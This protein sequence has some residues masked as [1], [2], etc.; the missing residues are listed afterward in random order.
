M[1]GNI[2]LTFAAA[3][4]VGTGAAQAQST[5]S[6]W[7]GVYTEAQAQHGEA[8]YRQNC[9]YCHGQNL[10][11]TFEIAPLMGR[12]MPYWSGTTL[13]VLMDYVNTAMPLGR[14][15]AVSR[16]D[17]ADIIAYILKMNGLPAGGSA[18][19]ADATALKAVTFDPAKPEPVS[20]SSK[21]PA[22]RRR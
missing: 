12:F 11:G 10:A 15:G 5:R 20:P 8:L 1:R 7:D 19:G 21:K 18:L 4:A 17:D 13:D 6:I 22:R 9:A 3:L 14:L 16:A 2:L